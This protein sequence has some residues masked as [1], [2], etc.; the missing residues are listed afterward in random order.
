MTHGEG[1]ESSAVS[2]TDPTSMKHLCTYSYLKGNKDYMLDAY[3]FAVA[4]ATDLYNMYASQGRWT[5]CVHGVE[6]A[7]ITSAERG[8]RLS[9]WGCPFAHL[10]NTFSSQSHQT[11]HCARTA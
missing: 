8:D 11:I 6:E 3:H 7:R 2:L 10:H 5:M 9:P 1:R 4:K